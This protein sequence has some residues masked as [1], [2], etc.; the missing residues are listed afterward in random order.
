MRKKKLFLFFTF[1]LLFFTYFLLLLFYICIHLSCPR[2]SFFNPRS[3]IF[4]R[5]KKK[6]V[7]DPSIFFERGFPS[8]TFFFGIY[9][10]LLAVRKRECLECIFML[11]L[12]IPYI[13][14]VYTFFCIH[15]YVCMT[16]VYWKKEKL[17]SGEE[18]WIFLFK[19]L[20]LPL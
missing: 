14:Y 5:K 20:F 15:V 18:V 19:D 17:G 13:V 3:Y 4:W 12:C 2:Y 1:H 11:L 7:R 9:F 10:Q 6:K 8:L 16:H